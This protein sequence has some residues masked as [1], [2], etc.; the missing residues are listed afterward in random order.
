M[1]PELLYGGTPSPASDVFS[2]GVVVYQII[3]G[4]LPRLDR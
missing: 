3:A 2:F 1:A 4:R